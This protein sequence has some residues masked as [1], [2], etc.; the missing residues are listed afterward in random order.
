MAPGHTGVELGFT[1]EESEPRV[2]SGDVALP[3][4]VRAV[5]LPTGQSS[6]VFKRDL[7]TVP[8]VRMGE[9]LN[10]VG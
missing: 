1:L 3:S 4:A 9:E 5:C 8:M 7:L 2:L 6:T 10:P